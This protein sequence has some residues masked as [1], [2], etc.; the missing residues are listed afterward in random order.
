MAKS[1][2]NMIASGVNT[3]VEIGPGKVLAGLIKRINRSVSIYNINDAASI[4][5]FSV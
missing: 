1:I 2:E 5:N 4:Q 3:F